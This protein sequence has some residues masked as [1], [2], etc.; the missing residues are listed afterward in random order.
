MNSVLHDK[1]A[2]FG[3]K[4]SMQ[5]CI[6]PYYFHNGKSEEC[7]R[8]DLRWVYEG[9]SI[10]EVI[11]VQERIPL[12]IGDHIRR[13]ARTAELRGLKLP[14]GSGG[15]IR[16]IEDY[17]TDTGMNEGNLKIVIN[18][19]PDQS[20]G[21][22]YLI[23]RIIHHYPTPEMYREGVKC[24]LHYAER[25]QPEAKVINPRLRN[26]IFKRLIETAHYEALLVNRQGEITEGSRSNV[27]FIRGE[28]LYT[29]PDKLVL[30]GI[31]RAQVIRICMDHGFDLQMTAINAND[32]Q[33]YDAAF[34]TG[35]SIRIL[36][37][38]T[39]GKV[40]FQTGHSLLKQLHTAYDEGVR[41]YIRHYR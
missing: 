6:A 18:H 15:I 33:K 23:Y 35:T 7:D 37:V 11:R 32:L 38:S 9:E 1:K 19:N 36:P 40:C 24:L 29:A 27:F 41:F 3:T 20:S 31:S 14:A 12:F 17:I 16:D 39:I 10:Y 34:L 25:F 28:T 4:F 13:L 21:Y 8:F 30:P 2:N 5:E 22:H 26:T